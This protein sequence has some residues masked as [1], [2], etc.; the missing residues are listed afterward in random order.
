M[1]SGDEYQSNI[2]FA[3]NDNSGTLR[4][5]IRTNST[6]VW[7]KDTV[8]R[9]TGGE[10]RPITQISTTDNLL[11]VNWWENN[12]ECFFRIYNLSISTWGD[13]ERAWTCPAN[14]SVASENSMMLY[15]TTQTIFHATLC[16]L[17]GDTKEQWAYT[18][19]TITSTYLTVG[20]NN[21]TATT[22]DVGKNLS[23]VNASLY[24]DSINFSQIGFE[25]AN[26]TRYVFFPDWGGN[27]AV[28]VTANGKFYIL[29]NAVGYWR[30]TYP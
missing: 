14:Y 28:T 26:G 13:V 23:Q 29:C 6:G 11:Y 2:Y 21:F 25:Y 27:V 20:W 17:Y 1:W 3:F 30:H 18:Y 4:C 7:A 9:T 5:S 12:R 16:K 19:S 15:A 24:V 10:I 22:M 8:L